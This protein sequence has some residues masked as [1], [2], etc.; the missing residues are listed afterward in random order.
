M[1]FGVFLSHLQVL[2]TSISFGSVAWSYSSLE[3]TDHRPR[4]LFFENSRAVVV[5]DAVEDVE[6][7]LCEIPAL[8]FHLF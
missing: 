6:G 8:L 2:I 5:A 1:S 7:K 4:V 3:Y